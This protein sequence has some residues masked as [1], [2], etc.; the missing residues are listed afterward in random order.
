MGLIC[1]VNCGTVLTAGDWFY[2]ALGISAR[3]ADGRGLLWLVSLWLGAVVAILVYLAVLPCIIRSHPPTLHCD[4]RGYGCQCLHINNKH[5]EPV[6][7]CCGFFLTV[8]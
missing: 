7:V 5:F 4:Y 8:R 3:W 6:L 1:A 2:R